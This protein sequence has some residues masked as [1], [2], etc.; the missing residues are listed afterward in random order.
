VLVLQ[1]VSVVV[2]PLFVDSVVVA[3]HVVVVQLVLLTVVNVVVLAHAH[4]PHVLAPSVALAVMVGEGVVMVIAVL[5]VCVDDG[6]DLH[7]WS[8]V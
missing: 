8:K 2:V 3:H 1:C 7:A 4:L 6:V 5:G